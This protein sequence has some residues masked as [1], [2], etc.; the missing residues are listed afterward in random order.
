[1]GG[2][3]EARQS[4]QNSTGREEGEGGRKRQTQER[5]QAALDALSLADV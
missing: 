3:E 1:V 2:R 4:E 5:R